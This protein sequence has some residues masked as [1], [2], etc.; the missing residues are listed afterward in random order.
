MAFRLVLTAA[1][2]IGGVIETS[3]APPRIVIDGPSD[4]M[5]VYDSAGDVTV[6]IGGPLGRLSA[7]DVPDNTFV[8]LWNGSTYYGMGDPD[9]GPPNG[10][11]TA[12]QIAANLPALALFLTSGVT[13]TATNTSSLTL[14][15]G[16][17]GATIG[18]ATSQHSEFQ[19]DVWVR[20]IAIQEDVF[21]VA[22][23]NPAAPASNFALGSTAS[24][25]YQALQYRLDTEDNTLL[26]GAM[27]VTTTLVA[28]TYTVTTLSGRYLPAKLY[29]FDGLHVSSADV[30]KAVIRCTLSPGTGLLQFNTTSAIA[31][32]DNF[33]FD[34][35]IPRGNLP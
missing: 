32:N 20:G 16:V 24:A 23:W 1:V 11:S 30:F 21:G 9:A 31:L 2:I 13:A 12:A 28:G 22:A 29:A 7:I 14:S 3:Q 25:T 10:I 26:K 35:T 19:G 4:T 18:T 27:H 17:P 5:T 34:M 15:P 33:Y 6:R 8:T